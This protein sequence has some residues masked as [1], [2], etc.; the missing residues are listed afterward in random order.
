GRDA[1][2]GAVES[3]AAIGGRRSAVERA[4]R[5]RRVVFVQRS[6]GDRCIATTRRLHPCA[7]LPAVGAGIVSA[8]QTL[9]TSAAPRPSIQRFAPAPLQCT[10]PRA[11]V[12]REI[13]DPPISAIRITFTKLS[14]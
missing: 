11:G 3:R 13:C 6:A 4:V 7:P 2:V 9:L 12:E 14:I 1:A 8:T 10:V 5:V